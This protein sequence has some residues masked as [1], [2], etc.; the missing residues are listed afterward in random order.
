MRLPF[1][2]LI[3]NVAQIPYHHCGAF[4]RSGHS[5]VRRRVILL[6]GVGSATRL[7][8]PDFVGA[9]QGISDGDD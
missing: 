6:P 7:V 9:E 2:V 8:T 3:Q 4:T 5:P 1:Q